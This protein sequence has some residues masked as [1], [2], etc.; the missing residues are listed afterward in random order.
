MES[1]VDIMLCFPHLSFC[2]LGKVLA[3]SRQLLPFPEISLRELP[4]SRSCLFSGHSISVIGW[5]RGVKAWS[6]CS[7]LGRLWKSSV[8]SAGTLL[9]VQAAQLLPLPSPTLF[10]SPTVLVP[11]DLPL[12]LLHHRSHLC[13]CF[14]GAQIESTMWKK[15]KWLWYSLG[16]LFEF[17]EGASSHEP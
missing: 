12:T 2:R 8:R 15:V 3:D 6:P 4:C 10:P 11:E 7:T 5:C 9:T 13:V 1:R 17:G 14:L 16:L